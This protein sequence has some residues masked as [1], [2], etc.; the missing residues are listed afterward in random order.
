MRKFSKYILLLLFVSIFSVVSCSKEETGAKVIVKT[1]VSDQG[2]Y[3]GIDVNLVDSHNSIF[4]AETN[5]EGIAIIE[6]LEPGTYWIQCDY[7]INGEGHRY[8]YEGNDFDLSK[9][10]EKTISV[11][12]E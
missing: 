8:D 5:S 3:A 7:Q 12:L 9:D 2:V 1:T 10:E 4:D 11:T 6:N